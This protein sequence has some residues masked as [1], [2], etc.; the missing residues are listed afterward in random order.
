MLIQ[1]VRLLSELIASL[2][3]N[4]FRK[5]PSG[6]PFQNLSKVYDVTVVFVTSPSFEAV[7]CFIC[8]R[9]IVAVARYR[10][11]FIS[12][13]LVIIFKPAFTTNVM[14]LHFL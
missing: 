1:N 6:A 7:N 9:R 10:T 11:S 5:R 14:T 12:K 2:M 3:R 13:L 8:G 4:N